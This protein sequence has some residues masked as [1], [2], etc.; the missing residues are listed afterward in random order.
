MTSHRFIALLVSQ[1]L[2]Q[3]RAAELRVC[4]V[5]SVVWWH[6][7]TGR[8]ARL[9]PLLEHMCWNSTEVSHAVLAVL[10][11]GIAA[12][13]LGDQKPFFRGASTDSG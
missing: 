10:V 5:A 9:Q 4:A 12:T 11:D 8:C 6:G 2:S 1:L 13:D 3:T 7:V